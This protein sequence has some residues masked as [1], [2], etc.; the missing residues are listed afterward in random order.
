MA[1]RIE[2]DGR[3]GF[4]A[5]AIVNALLLL[6]VN[7]HETWRPW[8]NGVVTDAFLEVLWAVNLALW[9]QVLGN[10][11]LFFTHPL[12]FR[13]MAEFGFALVTVVSSAVLYQ[14]FPF[15]FAAIQ[16]AWLDVVARIFLIVGIAGGALG[17]VV[18]MV[19]MGRGDG[20]KRRPLD[21]GI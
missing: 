5:A 20:S 4:L 17:M 13:R 2:K 16:Q 15:D 6:A 11:L 8:T 14:V 21:A 1:K 7:A 18:A 3:F 19:R 9:V 10:A 12:W